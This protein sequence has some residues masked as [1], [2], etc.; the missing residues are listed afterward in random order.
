VPWLL[1]HAAGSRS[2]ELFLL[3]VVGL[4]LGTALGT[5]FA[6]LSLA[7]GAFL[8]GLAVA[9]SE[10]RTQVVAEV[11]PLRDLFTSL[12]FVSVGMLIDPHTL[13]TQ[14]GT[15]ALL[16]ATVLVGKVLITA[17]V[18][19]GLGLPSPAALLAA[20]TIAPVGE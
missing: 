17:L 20:L 9:E 8:A 5:Q 4:A 3:S 11:L 16:A 10:Y 2:R 1:A 7:F 18:V 6:G 12:F 13:L 15:V 19:R 14:A